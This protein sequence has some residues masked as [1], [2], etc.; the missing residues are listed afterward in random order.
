MA[1]SQFKM[2]PAEAKRRR[3]THIQCQAD[4][5]IRAS[6]AYRQQGFPPF[7]LHPSP[8]RR[9]GWRAGGILSPNTNDE[10]AI[11]QLTSKAGWCQRHYEAWL[12]IEGD[13]C[14]QCDEQR[15][16]AIAERKAAIR[17]AEEAKLTSAQWV[18]IH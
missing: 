12:P 9:L 17:A 3:Y 1:A 18:G 5:A 11:V 4:A 8:M 6:V 13:G 7:P 16:R 10:G 15:D 2:P 14:W